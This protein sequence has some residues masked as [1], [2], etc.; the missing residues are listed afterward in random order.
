MPDIGGGGPGQ[1]GL[2]LRV[3]WG[4]YDIDLK[5]HRRAGSSHWAFIYSC[6]YVGRF[7]VLGGFFGTISQ[8]LE[9]QCRHV[10]HLHG[11]SSVTVTVLCSLLSLM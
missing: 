10:F 1:D 8:S 5:R 3:C 2:E 7:F 4:T 6:L 9:M 11:I